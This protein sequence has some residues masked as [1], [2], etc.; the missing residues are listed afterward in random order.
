LVTRVRSRTEEKVDSIGLLFF[1]CSQCSA[2]KS[3][4]VR[5]ASASSVIWQPPWATW[6]RSHK[7]RPRWRRRLRGSRPGAPL[8]R[9]RDGHDPGLLGEQPGERDLGR[10]GVLAG[11]DPLQQVDQ[12]LVGLACLPPS[13]NQPKSRIHLLLLS[14]VRS[15][16]STASQARPAST[17]PRATLATP[18][19][20]PNNWVVVTQRCLSGPPS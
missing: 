8:D 9:C 13:P 2:G 4:K 11:C 10:G 18:V 15:W 7:P 17:A 1:R 12:G 20:A 3:K 6:C 16:S 19:K 5:S 14:S